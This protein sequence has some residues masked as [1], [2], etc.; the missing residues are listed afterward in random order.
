MQQPRSGLR[1][2]RSKFYSRAQLCSAS[3]PLEARLELLMA[4]P[5]VQSHCPVHF[6][7]HTADRLERRTQRLFWPV[8]RVAT[9]AQLQQL[10]DDLDRLSAAGIVHGD[11][12]RKNLRQSPQRLHLT[13]WEPDLF[14]ITQG[15]MGP[16][17]TLPWWHPLDQAQQQVSSLTDLLCFARLCEQGMPGKAFVISVRQLNALPTQAFSRL[18]VDG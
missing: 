14:Q 10:A 4:S 1:D 9:L 7:W 17:V 5:L 3:N 18:L 8:L 15:R 11:I 13:D 2:F 6:Y 16:M 12:H